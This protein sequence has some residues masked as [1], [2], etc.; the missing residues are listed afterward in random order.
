MTFKGLFQ[1]K[2]F[3][4]TRGSASF[5]FLCLPPLSASELLRAFHLLP[6][7]DTG[8][9]RGKHFWG[10]SLW[11]LCYLLLSGSASGSAMPKS[12]MEEQERFAV[13]IILWHLHVQGAKWLVKVCAVSR[14][15]V[16]RM[17]MQMLIPGEIIAWVEPCRSR[18]TKCCSLSPSIGRGMDA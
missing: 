8:W 6:F 7:A 18:R 1:L 15:F 5:G 9:F 11:F 13:L 17:S 4:G 12:D 2:W 10:Y 3:Y 14:W 16:R